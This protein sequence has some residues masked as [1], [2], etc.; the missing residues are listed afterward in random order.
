MAVILPDCAL[1]VA[2]MGPTAHD[3]SGY[4]IPAT[5]TPGGPALPGRK[6]ERPD[7][8]WVLAVDPSMW[9]VK[10][11]DLI[12]EP[13]TGAEWLVVSADLLTNSADPAVDYVRVEGEIR[14]G[15]STL[16]PGVNPEGPT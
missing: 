6:K 9:P 5:R 7:H 8:S 13:A 4:P 16:P 1:T 11:G 12:Q 3:P 15:V 10:E 14:V 2:R